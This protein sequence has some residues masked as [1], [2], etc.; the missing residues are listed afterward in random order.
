[1]RD[2]HK[3]ALAGITATR[4]IVAIWKEGAR[5]GASATAKSPSFAGGLVSDFDKDL[6]STF[7]T[8]WEIST[9]AFAGGKSVADLR[10]TTSEGRIALAVKGEIREGFATP[11]AGAML[12]FAQTRMEPVSVKPARELSFMIRGN[13]PVR[14][15][16]FSASTG[17][18]PA[19]Y[20]VTVTNESKRVQIPLPAFRTDGADV[21]ALHFSGTAASFEFEIDD[22][23]L[24]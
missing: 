2:A 22:V 5:V 21:Q 4:A 12:F 13:A 24:R 11:W 1:M 18:V 8:V 3:R 20:D 15:M 17:G 10:R 14:A 23:V 19:S 9:D 7:G 16:L 6:G